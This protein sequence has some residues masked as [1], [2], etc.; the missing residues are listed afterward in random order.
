MPEF[1][2][3]TIVCNTGPIIGLSRVGLSHLMGALFAKVLLPEA[4]VAELRAKHAGDADQI[5][6]AISLAEII[7]LAHPPDPL[8]IAELDP[9]EASVIQG[10]R[11][12]NLQAVLIDERRAIRIASTI[13]GLHV[14]GTCAMLVE[15]KQ[16]LLISDVRTPL[17]GMIAAGYFIGPQL[18]AECLRRAGE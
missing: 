6:H 10:A 5:K 3:R 7:S 16:R 17:D 18:R 14:R 2:D 1:F 13:Y 4:V 8:L 15:A 11:E 9:G 12:R